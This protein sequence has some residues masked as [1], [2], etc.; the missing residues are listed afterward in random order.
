MIEE[1]LSVFLLVTAGFLENRAYLLVAFFLGFTSKERVACAGL[2]FACECGEEV[3]LGLAAF[4]IHF[5]IL[6]D[7]SQ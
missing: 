1:E 6:L 3:L 7:V 2:G 5:L 4:K